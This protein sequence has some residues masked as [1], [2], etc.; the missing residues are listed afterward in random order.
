MPGQINWVEMP[1]ADTAKAR[2]FYGGLFGDR[3][4]VGQPGDRWQ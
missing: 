4:D 1:A 2:A 3:P